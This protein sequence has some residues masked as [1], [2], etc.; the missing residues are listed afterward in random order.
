[1]Q[2]NWKFSFGAKSVDVT[3]LIPLLHC[4]TSANLDYIYQGDPLSY[5]ILSAI[6]IVEGLTQN[7]L[8]SM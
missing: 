5:L 3:V 2:K 4:H 7:E 6:I 1:M 8:C